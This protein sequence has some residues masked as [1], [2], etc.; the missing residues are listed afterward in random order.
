MRP[1][2]EILLFLFILLILPNQAHPGKEGV[3]ILRVSNHLDGQ[4]YF[5]LPVQ[6][7][8]WVKVQFLHSYDRL[9]IWELY[10]VGMDGK[11]S[12][13]KMGGQSLLNGQGF[14]YE[15]YRNLPDGTWE[16]GEIKEK[17]E[18]ICFF[19]GTKGDADHEIAVG[20]M[21][22]K[23]SEYISPGTIVCLSLL[24]KGE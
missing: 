9:P 20:E 13:N 21:T 6:A 23:L 4:A 19:M 12:F 3:F 15:G 16:I 17:K 14:F 22:I 5:S 24:E 8:E 11:F 2:P 10:R 1:R 7:G 18:K